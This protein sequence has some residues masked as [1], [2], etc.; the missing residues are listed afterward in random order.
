VYIDLSIHL[1]DTHTRSKLNAALLLNPNLTPCDDRTQSLPYTGDK[2]CFGIPG[3]SVECEDEI[4]ESDKLDAIPTASQWRRAVT[5]LVRFYMGTSDVNRYE[6]QDG[7]NPDVEEEELALQ[8]DN[9]STRNVQN[10]G[11]GKFALGTSNIDQYEGVVGNDRDADEEDEASQADDGS[12]QNMEDWGC[13]T[14]EC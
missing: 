1:F 13:S 5:E 8:V 11:H 4:D 10:W 14:R 12:T 2:W 6:S 3:G 7:Y 9:G